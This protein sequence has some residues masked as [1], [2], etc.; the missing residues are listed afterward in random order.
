MRSVCPS[1]RRSD[2]VVVNRES[3]VAPLKGMKMIVVAGMLALGLTG[4]PQAP[5]THA[6]S[7]TN[8]SLLTFVAVDVQPVHPG[9]DTLCH[10]RVRIRNAGT[11]LAS[12]LTFQV[13]VNGKPL[14][15]FLNH[16][17]RLPLEA[18]KETEVQLFNFWSS[19][20]SR[21]YPSDG[22][23]V[24]EVRLT[25][26]RWA[27]PGTTNTAT[28]AALVQPLPAPFVVTLTR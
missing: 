17:W 8:N 16:V 4:L 9:P 21:P 10:L 23:L 15:N 22:R 2:R 19:E 3:R 12:D 18:G 14:G 20:Y 13:T 5:P 11:A 6:P 24:I 1:R 26:A 25:G 27:P 7:S 28:L